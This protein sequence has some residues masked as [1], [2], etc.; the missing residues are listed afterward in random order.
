MNLRHSA[1]KTNSFTVL[2]DNDPVDATSE[3]QLKQ[4]YHKEGLFDGNL[5][6][7]TGSQSSK[8]AEWGNRSF[9]F[10]F[11]D[12]KGRAI[13]AFTI[14]LRELL[15]AEDITAEQ[16]GIPY[17]MDDSFKDICVKLYGYLEPAYNDTDSEADKKMPVE[18]DSNWVDLN[19]NYSVNDSTFWLTQGVNCNSYYRKAYNEE[20]Q[21][22]VTDMTQGWTFAATSNVD[23]YKAYKI[24]IE[25]GNGLKC[26]QIYQITLDYKMQ[27]E[28]D[29]I[30]VE[31]QTEGNTGAGPNFGGYNPGPGPN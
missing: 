12:K 26:S 3:Q 20:G 7:V 6:K 2:Y 17:L 1:V 28:L 19:P 23:N 8:E 29:Y 16:G 15:I 13:N 31:T 25:G 18:T 30:I 5:T 21:V 24:K 9:G 10:K 14:W 27:Y 22:M 11:K 4:Y